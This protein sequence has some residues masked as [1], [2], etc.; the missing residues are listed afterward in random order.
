M[1]LN[2]NPDQKQ[3]ENLSAAAAT[4]CVGGMGTHW[5]CATPR[6]RLDERFPHLIPD[7][8]MVRIFCILEFYYIVNIFF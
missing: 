6:L 7:S 1:R 2:Q 5:T 8:E 4:Y 3:E